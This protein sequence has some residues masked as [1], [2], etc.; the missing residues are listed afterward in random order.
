MLK[1]RQKIFALAIFFLSGFS[2]LTYE[3]IWSRLLTLVFGTSIEAISAVITAFM[4]GLAL[5]SYF[6]G[7]HSD[8]IRRYLA[9]Y[10]V[11]E[12]LIGIS[13]IILYHSIINLPSLIKFFQLTLHEHKPFITVIIYAFNF[14]LVAIP[15]TL[16]GA[17]FPLI[18]KHYIRNKN[19]VGLG[20]GMLYGMNTLGAVA[21]TFLSGFFLIPSFGVMETNYIAAFI[22]IS[23]GVSALWASRRDRRKGIISK[24]EYLKKPR[25]IFSPLRELPA[26]TVLAVFFISGFAAMAYEVTWTRFLVMIIG[27]S[28]YAFSAI[29]T[30]FLFGIALGSLILARFVDRVRD[31]I[32]LLAILEIMIFIFVA[33]T[34]PFLDNMPFLFQFLFNVFYASFAYVE[35]ITFIVVLILTLVPTILMGAAFPVVNRI[36]TSK[37]QF[38]GSSIGSAYSA[39]TVGGIFG[40]MLAGFYYIP[41]FGVEKTLL[42]LSSLNLFAGLA[43]LVQDEKMN[44]LVKMTSV[45]VA[46]AFFAF[47]SSWLPEWN[48]NYL[49]RGVYVY[50]DWF[51]E[52]FED[53]NRDL[54]KFFD[55][56][57]DLRWYK[58]GRAGTVAVTDIKGQ[59]TLQINGKTEGSTGEADMRTQ[60]MVTALPLMLKEEAKDVAIIG[61]GTGVS[62]GIAEQFKV[63]RIDCVELSEEV[64]EASRF[65]SDRNHNALNNP[66]LNL[67]I[68]DGRNFLTYA[69]RKYDVIINEP[70]NPWI[71]GVS[72]LFTLEFFKIAGNRLKNNGIMAQWI[73]MYSLKTEELKT[74]LHT[75][76]EV[77]PYVSVWMFS[78]SDLIVLG[79]KGSAINDYSN[80]ESAFYVPS[81]YEDLRAIN[82]HSPADVMKAYLFG[83]DKT[84]LFAGKSP[85]NTDNYP[86]IEFEAPKALYSHSEGDNI[87]ALHDCC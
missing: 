28:T 3:I 71:S 70:S 21:G 69:D 16:M 24:R 51:G 72:N 48:K 76:K 82:I 67:I 27:N 26:I 29:L 42:L 45:L 10:A 33:A 61:L 41:S 77:F 5:G 63:N 43:L 9:A 80:I 25:E 8:F 53:V 44:N 65:F 84:V 34:L 39:N 36:I 64:I 2:A 13:S 79:S 20:I 30:V 73:Q 32:L 49:N 57:Y 87:R 4:F 7:R 37:L 19:R 60:T 62:V 74:L 81:L 40:A 58:E 50:A 52:N 18:S 15:T 38:L 83:S 59:L 78:P 47:Y 17:T 12:I 46:G 22:S 23:L 35:L 66:K 6:A 75:F 55:E 54:R 31:L 86:V 14:F 56:R 1:S 85:L 11:T 68:G